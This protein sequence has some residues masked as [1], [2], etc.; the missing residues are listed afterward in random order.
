MIIAYLKLMRLYYSIPLATGFIVI[1]SYLT[2][3]NLTPI[4]SELLFSF[5][6]LLSIISGAYVL[7]DAVDIKIDEINCPNRILPSKKLTKQSSVY[8]SIALFSIGLT[9]SLLCN[10]SFFIGICLI[11]SGLIFYDLYS[12][13]LG[14]AKIILVGALTTSLYPLSLTLADAGISPRVNVLL[15]HPIWLFFTSAY[16]EMLKDIRDIKGDSTIFN[17]N[18]FI[19]SNRF[20]NSVK[21]I[22]VLASLITLLPYLLKYCGIIYL[23]ASIVAITLA[24][25]SVFFRPK[26]AIKC[27]YLEI[28]IIT[29]GS[30]LDLLVFGS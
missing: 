3:G 15:I 16:Y 20:I 13:K 9:L 1:M 19:E 17:A 18:R 7:N 24:L 28:F 25:A 30:M 2:D 8:F 10:F 4:Q 5:L 23:I 21:L 27:I 26:N 11:S 29:T 12:K 14:I 6:S 22:T